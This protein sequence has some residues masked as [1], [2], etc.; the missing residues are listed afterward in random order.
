MVELL[1]EQGASLKIFDHTVREVDGV[2]GSAAHTYQAGR[3]GPMT[4]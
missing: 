4:G 2:L 1:R 3:P